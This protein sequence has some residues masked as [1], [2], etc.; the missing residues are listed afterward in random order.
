MAD[1]I[2]VGRVRSPYGIHGWAWM[3]SFTDNPASVFEWMP[4]ILT[5][6][7]DGTGKRTAID[8]IDTAPEIWKQR[9]KR[10]IVKLVGYSDRS[11]VESLVN[12]LI[13]VDKGHL[14]QLD[15]DEFYWRD[16]EGCRVET[17]S[18][19]ALGVVKEVMPTGANDVLV[20]VGNTESIDQKERLIPFIRQTVPKIDM[21]ERVI[22]VNWDPEF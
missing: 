13:E 21:T 22:R 4:W 10:Y 15:G 14:P 7:G 17:V 18:K 2:V 5:R 9:G 12:C 11:G 3:D 8:R 20:V 16:L 19:C 6:K 1:R